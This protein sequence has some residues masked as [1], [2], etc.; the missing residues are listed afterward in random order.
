MKEQKLSP[1]D[2][3]PAV[4]KFCVCDPKGANGA[5]R[6][7]IVEKSMASDTVNELIITPFLKH[8]II[9]PLIEKTLNMSCYF[10]NSMVLRTATL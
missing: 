9:L 10:S 2:S 8:Y 7:C 6:D 1:S 5:T 3:S 4:P